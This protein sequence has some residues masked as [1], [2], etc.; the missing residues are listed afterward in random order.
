[1]ATLCTEIGM[2][3]YRENQKDWKRFLP[4]NIPANICHRRGSACEGVCALC[5]VRHQRGWLRARSSMLKDTYSCCARVCASVYT[6]RKCVCLCDSVWRRVHRHAAVFFFLCTSKG[7]S[8]HFL[9]IFFFYRLMRMRPSAKC[10]FTHTLI[11][12]SCWQVW[13][14]LFACM[15]VCAHSSNMPLWWAMAAVTSSPYSPYFRLY[16]PPVCRLSPP[17][18]ITRLNR[19]PKSVKCISLKCSFFITPPTHL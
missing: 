1:M 12:S 2:P 18:Y 8:P 10:F 9:R 6:T 7:S 3:K 16:M 14:D 11:A 19:P 4:G 17:S 15:R 13:A 5:S